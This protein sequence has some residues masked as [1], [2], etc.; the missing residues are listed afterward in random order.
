MRLR[1]FRSCERGV[2]VVLA[3]ASTVWVATAADDDTRKV[4]ARSV[5]RYALSCEKPQGGFGPADRPY[6]EVSRTYFA[7]AAL[8]VLGAEVPNPEKI[9]RD[10]GVLRDFTVQQSARGYH[11][12]SLCFLLGKPFD[13]RLVGTA[14]KWPGETSGT[15]HSV[16][17]D[18]GGFGG[19]T[20]SYPYTKVHNTYYGMAILAQGGRE[21]EKVRDLCKR[22]PEFLA[23][24]Q[25]P[26]GSWNNFPPPGTKYR[27]IFP[28][29]RGIDYWDKNPEIGHVHLTWCAVKAYELLGI[30]VPNREKTIVWLRAC[31]GPGGGFTRAP[32]RGTEDIWETWAAV[33]ALKAL[34]SEPRDKDAAVAYINSLQNADGGFGDRPGWRS[35]LQCT[36]NAVAALHALTGDARKA[37]TT[38]EVPV[39]APVEVPDAQGMKIYCAFSNYV[40]TG[41]TEV[42]DQAPELGADVVGIWLLDYKGPNDPRVLPLQ[43]HIADRG[44]G[45]TAIADSTHYRIAIYFEGTGQAQHGVLGIKWP[46]GVEFDR[47]YIRSITHGAVTHEE[48]AKRLQLLKDKGGLTYWGGRLDMESMERISFDAAIEGK[49]GYDCISMPGTSD[50]FKAKPWLERYVGRLPL[51]HSVSTMNKEPHP[52]V[53]FVRTLFVA[54]SPSY[55]DFADAVKA[56]RVVAVFGRENSSYYGPPEWVQYV[57]AHEDE[58]RPRWPEPPRGAE[59]FAPK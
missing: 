46:P 34:A 59:R 57:K 21:I 24:R 25:N 11:K 30:E 47:A 31:Q 3:M 2:C 5:V 29:V 40:R 7:V 17:E 10:R 6:A 55:K 4:D 28:D 51:L 36:F 52:V 54:R 1:P 53:Y 18:D 48:L 42:L 35:R 43:K 23:S 9:L 44:T 38:K 50:P 49:G 12:A 16:P 13:M 14:H 37:I 26:G 39:P 22:T 45:V 27:E 41:S 20:I 32:G 15:R 56:N 8:K 19:H 58:W 33:S